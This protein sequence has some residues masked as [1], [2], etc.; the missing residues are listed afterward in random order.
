MTTDTAPVLGPSFAGVR[1]RLT[2]LDGLRGVA[3]AVVVIFHYL[4]LLHP[5]L[6][7]HYSVQPP[8]LS[9]TP[10]AVLWNGTFAVFVFFVLSGY[11]MAAAAKRRQDRFWSNIV[12]RY[13]RLAVPAAV[14]VLLA[15]ALLSF[16]PTAADDLAASQANPSEWI[17]YTLQAPLPPVTTAVY[18][19]LIGSFWSGGSKFNNVLWTMQIELVGSAVLFAV[20]WASGRSHLRLALMVG[21][22][23]AVSLLFLR[24]AYLCFVSGA[25]L[26]EARGRGLLDRLPASAGLWALVAG[27][28]LGAPGDGTAERWGLVGWPDRLTPGVDYGLVPVLAATLIVL[29]VLTLGKMTRVLKHGVLQ[30]FGQVSFALYLIHVPLLYTVVAAAHLAPHIPEPIVF[31]MYLGVTLLMAQWFTLFVDAPVIRVL[32]RVRHRIA[33]TGRAGSGRISTLQPAAII[34]HQDRRKK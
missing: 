32:Q 23:A 13:F 29:S 17:D 10:V 16:F 33:Q 28:V 11:V 31:T 24:D 3:A 25:L 27:I 1:G 21:L 19:G 34:H 9:D 4:A 26:Y 6:L 5:G 15:L 8:V 12:V 22:F 30:W 14:S 7:P 18:D 2:E 20:Y